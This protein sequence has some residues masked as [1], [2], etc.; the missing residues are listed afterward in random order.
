MGSIYKLTCVPTGKSYIGKD[1]RG[2]RRAKEHLNGQTSQCKAIHSA[3]KKYGRENFVEEILHEGIAPELLADL[4][5]QAI[6][7][8]NTKA[9]NGYNLTDGG[10]GVAGYVFS[11]ESKK[12]MSDSHIG[13]TMPQEQRDKIS[14]SLKGK[15]RK[16]LSPEHRRNLSEVNTGKTMPKET[17]E[18]ISESH[19]NNPKVQEHLKNLAEQPRSAEARQK[20]SE[21]MTGFKHSEESKEIMREK[22][23]EREAKKRAEGYTV[24]D[25]T[26]EKQ[27]EGQCRAWASRN[28]VKHQA[29]AFYLTL[30][31]GLSIEEKRKIL[32]EKY[33]GLVCRSSINTWIREWNKESEKNA[34]N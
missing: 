6:R 16:P 5:R 12:K 9:P 17:R 19:K 4:E 3:I 33:L 14:E 28:P 26:R 31:L 23:R 18:K 7:E 32:Q 34:Q 10:D 1:T 27:S 13:K 8:H 29:K 2:N 15:K 21:A 22:G 11:E 25:E 24:S 20:Q 30:D